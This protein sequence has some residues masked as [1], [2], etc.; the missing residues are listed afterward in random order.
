MKIN[1]LFVFVLAGLIFTMSC[2]KPNDPEVIVPP[3]VS[4][5]YKI[6]TKYTTFGY[7]QDVV[8][9]G[10]LLYIAQGEG[11]LMIADVSDRAN[12]QTLSITTE[13]A[14]GYS[15]GVILK[16]TIVYLAAGSFGVT[17]LDASDVLMPFVTDYNTPMK[18]AKS[19]YIMGDFLISASSEQGVKF[20]DI[21]Y[22]TQLDVRGFVSTEGYAQDITVT[23]DSILLV[24]SGELG[25]SLYDIRDF[26]NGYGD[27]PLIGHCKLPGYSNAITI[28]EEE[29][30]AFLACGTSGLLVV[31]YADTANIH[32]VG[33]LDSGGY[34]K[35]IIYDDQKIF[36]TTEL[37]GL[38]IIDVSNFQSPTLIGL[39]DT[40]FALRLDIDDDY[41]YV[42]DEDEGLIIISRPN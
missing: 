39:I 22:P 38:Q 41:V 13:N 20:A 10:N 37:S 25:V 7:A 11:G 33:Q 29:S 14:R 6:V 15:A 8:V 32:I 24:A 26:Q 40:E 35:D 23:H 9:N 19:L 28:V 12:P 5:G 4:G 42:A 1:H 16:D 17:A 36:M 27:Y 2:G 3:D 31:N 30:I 34:A 21:S 18:P